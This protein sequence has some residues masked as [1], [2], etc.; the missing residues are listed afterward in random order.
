MNLLLFENKQYYI[1]ERV[2]GKNLV[3][4]KNCK[5]P[6]FINEKK[7]SRLLDSLSILFS[8]NLVTFGILSSKGYV[9]YKIYGKESGRWLDYEEYSKVVDEFGLISPETI[10]IG[11]CFSKECLSY[12]NKRV[13]VL[14]S[15]CNNFTTI[16]NL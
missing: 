6:P 4:Y 15:F 3:L 12:I 2:S 13:V 16:L 10:T 5:K 7:F 1:T 9:I 14:N 8:K 11:N